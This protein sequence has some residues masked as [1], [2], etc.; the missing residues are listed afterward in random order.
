[1]TKSLS[2]DVPGETL[3]CAL[4]LN[5]ESTLDE[6]LGRLVVVDVFVSV[7]KNTNC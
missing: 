1:M 3:A 5:A 2:E 7:P 6:E 4:F